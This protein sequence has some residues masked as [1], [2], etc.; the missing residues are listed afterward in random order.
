[1]PMTPKDRIRWSFTDVSHN[2]IDDLEDLRADN[3]AAFRG[4][5]KRLTRPHS[6]ED[7][8]SNLVLGGCQYWKRT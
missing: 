1:M 8:R 7:F 5:N 4:G 2:V 3:A 6:F